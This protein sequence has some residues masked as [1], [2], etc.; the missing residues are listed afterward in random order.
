MHPDVEALRVAIQS[1]DDR[2]T[3]LRGSLPDI[4]RAGI[5][6]AAKDSAVM[7]DAYDTLTRHASASFAEYI[8]RRVITAAV[9]LVISAGL[10][11][12]VITGQFQK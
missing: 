3:D 5:R 12:A 4:V 10:A 9:V 6:D 2:V 1:L 8:G 7:R 11:W